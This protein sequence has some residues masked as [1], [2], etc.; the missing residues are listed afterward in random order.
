MQNNSEA[1]AGRFLRVA[2]SFNIRLKKELLDRQLF[3]SINIPISL[4][5]R[6]FI[7]TWPNCHVSQFL[8]N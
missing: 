6:N 2:A 3:S 4:A 7:D 5:K 8:G 1:A